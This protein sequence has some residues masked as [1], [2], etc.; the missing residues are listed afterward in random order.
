MESLSERVRG[1]LERLGVPG[2]SAEVHAAQSRVGGLERERDEVAGKI[3]LW[4][5]IVFFLC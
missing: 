3:G 5:R 1:R 4:D 2:V